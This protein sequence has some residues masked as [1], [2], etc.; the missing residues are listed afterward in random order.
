MIYSSLRPGHS[1]SLWSIYWC[2]RTQ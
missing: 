2:I 1:F